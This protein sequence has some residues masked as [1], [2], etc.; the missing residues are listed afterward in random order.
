MI[1]LNIKKKLFSQEGSMTLDVNL[2]IKEESF[3]GLYGKSGAGKST[4][5]KILAGLV[6]PDQGFIINNNELWNE[7]SKNIFIKPQNRNIGFLFQDY[8]L[9]PNMTVRENI[10]FGCTGKVDKD[11]IQQLLDVTSLHNLDNK[12]PAILSGG[13][14][15]RVA[16]ARALARKPRLLLLDEP[17]S[18]LD[19]DTKLKLY[20]ELKII[21]ELFN[22]TTILI[23][24]SKEE[25]L[26]LCERVVVL[27]NGRIINQGNPIEIFTSRDEEVKGT[28]LDIIEEDN[29]DTIIASTGSET[30][31]IYVKKDSPIKVGDKV[32]IK[33]SKSAH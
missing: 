2:H 13:Q 29:E 15:Q 20:N 22:L 17:F 8:A 19:S 18:S 21:H 4:L 32:I 23:S 11:F 31:K 28:V 14:K 16:L 7:P 25:V 9:F 6:K 10:Q 12:Y 27:G 5:L 30:L 26:M 1:E 24:H 33:R 3:T